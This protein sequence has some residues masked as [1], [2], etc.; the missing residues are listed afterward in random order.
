[1]P[2]YNYKKDALTD[3][4]KG[5]LSA[6]ELDKIARDDFKSGIA[7]KKELSNFLSN[8]FTQ[9]VMS[10]TYGIPA[11]TLVKR[12]RGLMKF[13]EGVNEMDPH[14]PVVSKDDEEEVT[15]SKFAKKPEVTPKQLLKIQN[16][17]RKVNRKIKVY[18]SKHPVTKG[19]L[20]IELGHGHDNDD[21]IH[22][23]YAIL[24]KHTGSWRTGSMFNES[25]NEGKEPEVISQLRDIV[26]RKQNK[27]IKDPKSGKM[28]RVD[29]MSASVVTQVYDKI[30]KS[31]KDKFGKLSLPNMVNLA[32]KVAK[33]RMSDSVN[34]RINPK[35]YDA[36]VQYIDPK[37]KKKFVG[38]V[39]R[40]DNGEYKVNL[41]KDGRF[42][43]Y[44]LAKEKDLKIVSKSKKRTYESVN[45]GIS[46]F[47]ERHFGK[48]GIII[49]IDDN[50]KKVSAIF[51][52][53]KN[54]DKF[55]R[56]KPSDIKKLLDLA[57]KTKYPKAID[58]SVNEAYVVLYSPKKGVKPV[59]TAA[60]KDKKDAEKWAKD[61]GGI[62]MIVKKK[63]RYIDETKAQ[64]NKIKK[65][66]G[67]KEIKFYDILSNI[68]KKLGK[69][70]YRAFLVKSL[71]DFKINGNHY[72]YRSNAAAEEKLFQVS[73]VNTNEDLRNWF[74]SKWVNIGKKD[75]S[76]KHPPCGTS[77]NKKG[78]AKCV[79][80]KKAASMSKKEKESATRR[81]R[82]AQ[83]KSNRGG[84]SSAGQGKKPINVSTHTGGRKSGTGKG[85]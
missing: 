60:Y 2:K 76:G 34:E 51:K 54:A 70:K 30:N 53:K 62:T 43:K 24:K 35:F 59:T 69:N 38:D 79:P 74:K 58:E 37:S 29:L 7:T 64:I 77:G 23:I 19:Q 72:D 61:L 66:A 47:D 75:K 67:K 65:Q 28:M 82:A 68:E 22:K 9:D 50:G 83:N 78:Y 6:K 39:V 3:Y 63:V 20:D 56:N 21:E 81:K 31:N 10:D 1:M 57:K 5:K 14:Y 4:F 71:K 18:I 8:K 46:V 40:Y 26:K 48:K 73:E 49:M 33:P 27:K 11:G 42:E 16:D 15:E 80:A 85:S 45:E 25:V 36:R 84:K 13:A 17:V 55:N 52:D 32:Y 44:I 41:G 12:V